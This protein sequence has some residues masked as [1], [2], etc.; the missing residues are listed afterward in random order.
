MLL[1][2]QFVL[3]S[4][5]ASSTA[6]PCDINKIARMM[7]HGDVGS[8]D[9]I[10]EDWSLGKVNIFFLFPFSSCETRWFNGVSRDP[11]SAHP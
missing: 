4:V 3:L 10:F 5:V 1:F 2:Q 8:C 11:R 9:A 6:S 7:L